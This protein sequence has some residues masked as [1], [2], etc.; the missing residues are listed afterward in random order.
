MSSFAR[1]R[2]WSLR[3]KLLLLVVV[4]SMLPLIAASVV[5]YLGATAIVETDAEGVLAGRAE[6]FS[7]RI[8]HFNVE[9]LHAVELLARAPEVRALVASANADDPARAGAEAFLRAFGEGDPS[10]H[11]LVALD[12]HGTIVASTGGGLMGL[13]P[14]SEVVVR[15]RRGEASLSDVF[16]AGTEDR[17][18][19]VLAYAS[20]VRGAGGVVGE[21]VLFARAEALW[22]SV[23]RGNDLAGPG[24]F[25]TLV[26]E[27]GV[28]IAHSLA[29]KLVF[30]PIDQ[31]DA[32]TVERLSA[33]DR[34][35]P[36]T[37]ELLSNPSPIEGQIDVRRLAGIERHASRVFAPGNQSWNL[38]TARR[39]QSAPWTLVYF[40]PERTLHA[41]SNRLV[42]TTTAASAG[43]VLVALI[44]G[45]SLSTRIAR[46]I[47]ALTAAAE[48][49]GRGDAAARVEPRGRDEV[50]K[51]G[52]TFNEMAARL[53][54]AHESLERQVEDRTKAL[55]AAIE[56][57][58]DRNQQLDARSNEI[59]RRQAAAVAYGRALAALS[60]P[61]RL[62]RAINRAFGEIVE[63]SRAVVLACFR[64]EEGS[65]R[66][67]PLGGYAPGGALEPT[68]SALTGLAREAVE[69]GK[70]LQLDALPEDVELRYDA[71]LASGRPRS[72]LLV[73]L[74]HAGRPIG[75]LAAGALAPFSG[76][77]TALLSDLSIPLALTILRHELADQRDQ[78]SEEL[79]RQNE[80]LAR[81][82]EELQAQAEELRSQSEE[83]L[84]QQ[85]ELEST[86]RALEQANRMKSEFIAN[87]SHELRTP[88]NTVIGFTQ[89]LLDERTGALGAQQH[90][91][92][93]DIRDSGKHLLALINEILDLAKI[94]SGHATIRLE[95]V[96]VEVAVDEALAAAEGLAPKKRM[97]FRRQ[98]LTHRG[99]R[100]DRG[101]LRQILMNLLSNAAKFAPTGSAVELRAVDD[102][103]F[104]RFSVLDEGPGIPEHLREQLFEPFVQGEHPLVK[105]HE[106][107]GLGL[108]ISK[109]LVVRHGGTIAA[110]SEPG[111][112]SEFWFTIP[113]FEA[114]PSPASIVPALAVQGSVARKI[115]PSATSPRSALV[116]GAARVVLVVDDDPGARALLRAILES[117]GYRVEA[118]SSGDEGLEIAREARPSV[119]IVEWVSTERSGDGF[120]RSFSTDPRTRGCPIV[121][122]TTK[123]PNDAERAALGGRIAA[124]VEK[125]DVTRDG[126]LAVVRRA[127]EE[128]SSASDGALVLVVDDNELNREMCV[129][130]LERHGY[131]T[132]VAQ[133]GQEALEEVRRL[134]PALVLMDLSMPEL[135]GH[136]A[137][138]AIRAE[139]A[140]AGVPIVALTAHALPSDRERA[141]ASGFVGYLVKP[142]D[143]DE[144]V[145][146]VASVLSRR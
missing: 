35:G 71:T 104:V 11:H 97:T 81:Q 112:G 76:A 52:A 139:P 23:R 94:E 13:G 105:K 124:V 65:A 34:F 25:A 98:I 102:G 26:D 84:V 43:L 17:S 8:D 136:A 144:L 85:R 21:L 95:H 42:Q 49:L 31:M 6:Q 119:A 55:S 3:A 103:V 18:A 137:T 66:L 138:A 91:Y 130:M 135:D 111:R 68:A 7:E 131:R 115:A 107:T 33:L 123:A 39:M 74:S 77:A 9:Y 110:V 15:A 117:N 36:H 93:E 140:A 40:V 146:T 67:R 61:E 28:R 75:L 69:A 20:P 59:A 46:P 128:P 29:Q 62:D 89:L 19:P 14:A 1:F 10:V 56:A 90:R 64:V 47:Q 125:G 126:L 87:M 51:L 2:D 32:A 134:R 116:H 145:K 88:L 72:V 86:N 100:A 82:N 142:L 120:I 113:A 57:L 114:E 132:A 53:T 127:C 83:L 96:P 38:C 54:D 45:T 73:P 78:L 63:A 129:A 5:E 27:H 16:L 22:D 30:R 41:S 109:R 99:V 58:E 141:M 121:L 101:K 4:A 37:R 92:L 24:S 106:G 108:A 143:A 48:R 133:N 12:A 118:A 60:G 50:G 122:L 80:E 44:A 79:A 70:P